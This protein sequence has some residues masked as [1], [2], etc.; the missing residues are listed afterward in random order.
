VTDN[1]RRSDLGEF[2][3]ARRTEMRPESAGL[4]APSDPRRR[5]EGLRRED[6]AALASIGPDYDARI[7]QGRRGAPGS[8][9]DSAA[10]ALRL[11]E[12]GCDYFE[13]SAKDAE[14]RRQR[15]AQKVAPHFARLQDDLTRTPVLILGRRMDIL[16]WDRL[17][18]AL[19]TDFDAVRERH[20]TTC[21]S[22]SPTRRRAIRD[23]GVKTFSQPLVSELTLDWD[24][25]PCAGHPDQQLVSWN[26]APGAPSHRKLRE[27]TKTINPPAE[28]T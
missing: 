18:A 28:E 19:S 21:A 27:L 23:S 16:G 4:P 26:A 13:L 11:D 17:A 6:V 2:F 3:K 5:A 9:L 1:D 12:A 22:S 15:R 24:T 14:R 7:E 25:L 8:T 20:R 10:P